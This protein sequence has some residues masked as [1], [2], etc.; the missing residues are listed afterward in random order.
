MCGKHVNT[1]A[2]LQLH[3]TRIHSNEK[4]PPKEK[5]FKCDHCEKMFYSRGHLNEHIN[6]VH[7]RG[8]RTVQCP[9]CHKGF[10]TEKRMKKHL[11]NAHKESAE[12]F[13]NSWRNSEPF[14][15]IDIRLNADI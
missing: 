14:A 8:S 11:F 7:N 3:M 1:Y 10:N 12:E 9:V 15:T 4:L 5:T 2:S 13:R 6:G